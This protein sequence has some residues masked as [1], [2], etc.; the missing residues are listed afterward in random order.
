VPA[1][2]IFY[3]PVIFV[4]GLLLGQVLGRRALT[5][6]LAEREREEQRRKARQQDA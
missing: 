4:A 1:E 2:H 5:Q 3:I 6:E